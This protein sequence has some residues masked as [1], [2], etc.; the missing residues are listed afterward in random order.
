MS[1]RAAALGMADRH[2]PGRAQLGMNEMRIGSPSLQETAT[3]LMPR[4][5]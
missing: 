3:V 4:G 2:N 5:R 1:Q